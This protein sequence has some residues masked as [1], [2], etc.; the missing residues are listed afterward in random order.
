MP[1]PLP[2]REE[3]RRDVFKRI[4]EEERRKREFDD[5]NDGT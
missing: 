5:E 4:A 3:E 1:S 2:T